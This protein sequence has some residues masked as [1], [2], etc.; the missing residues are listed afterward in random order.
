MSV[1]FEVE[2]LLDVEFC[3]LIAAKATY[4]GAGDWSLSSL[5]VSGWIVASMHLQQSFVL[6]SFLAWDFFL[7]IFFV[8]QHELVCA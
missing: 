1:H 7:R 6:F 8:F 4:V 3:S 2:F 5:S